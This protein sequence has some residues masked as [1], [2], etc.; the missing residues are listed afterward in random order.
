MCAR[1]LTGTVVVF[2]LRESALHRAALRES[3][4]PQRHTTKK[5]S[6]HQGFREK[7]GVR[8]RA[9]DLPFEMEGNLRLPLS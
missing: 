9:S 1:A 6:L 8:S 3:D 5:G 7:D 4:K 2:R